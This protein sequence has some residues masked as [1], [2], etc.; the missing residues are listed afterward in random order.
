MKTPGLRRNMCAMSQPYHCV[1]NV[2][3]LPLCAMSQPYHCVKNVTALPLC[4]MSQPYHYVQC[5]SPTIICN[6]T[7][8]PLCAM[9]QPYHCVQCHSP[10]I[11]CM[12]NVTALPLC[13][14]S[15]LYHCV[16]NDPS[17]QW[18]VNGQPISAPNKSI[19]C[20]WPVV[21]GAIEHLSVDWPPILANKRV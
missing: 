4:A 19:S 2:T 5:H 9:S 15:Q 8:L 14:M 21:W 7:A 3:A 13:A 17:G 20:Y 11:M 12:C 10:T 16:K 1:K 6:V 18:L